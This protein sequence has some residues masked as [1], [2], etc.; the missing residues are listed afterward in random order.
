MGAILIGLGL[1]GAYYAGF[2]KLL[3]TGGPLVIQG[4][5]T[6]QGVNPATGQVRAYPANAPRV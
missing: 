4:V 3:Q 1:V 5:Q 6:L 2:T